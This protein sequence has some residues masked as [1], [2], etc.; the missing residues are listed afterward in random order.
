MHISL[1]FSAAALLAL[2]PYKT[3]ESASLAVEPVAVHEVTLVF[4]GD[5]MQHMPQVD[6]AWNEDMGIY[7]YDSCF[8]YIT[9]WLAGAEFFIETRQHFIV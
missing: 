8:K 3:S 4:T 5:I 2:V 6:A 7:I 9:P 1:I